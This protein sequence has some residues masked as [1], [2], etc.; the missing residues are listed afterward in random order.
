[1]KPVSA[2]AARVAMEEDE[3]APDPLARQLRSLQ[4][5]RRRRLQQVEAELLRAKQ[6]LREHGADYHAARSRCIGTRM[7]N[8]LRMGRMNGLMNR[9]L[10]QVR[11]LQAWRDWE[12]S[13]QQGM[14]SA[15]QRR[16][17][18]AQRWLAARAAL[19]AADRDRRQAFLGMEKLNL[20]EQEIARMGGG[21]SE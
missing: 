18:A 4:Q 2:A 9:R 17:E 21:G 10:L 13:M 14:A 19:D 11:E 1:M 8:S 7:L 6:A 15:R 16:D 3:L 12:D 20:L 5:I